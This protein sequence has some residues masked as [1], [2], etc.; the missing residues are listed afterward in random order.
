MKH[1]IRNTMTFAFLQGFYEMASSP[2][3][4]GRTHATSMDWNEAYDRG[5]NLAEAIFFNW[6]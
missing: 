1:Y 3:S 2:K 6:R 5:G 4:F